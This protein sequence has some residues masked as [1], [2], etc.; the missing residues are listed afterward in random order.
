[1]NASAKR[2]RRRQRRIALLAAAGALILAIVC[3]GLYLGIKTVLQK[4]KPATGTEV[5]ADGS[6]E[7]GSQSGLQNPSGSTVKIT[8]GGDIL[9]EDPILNYFNNGTWGSYMEALWPWL[10][11][12][13]LSVVNMEVPIGGEELGITGIDYSFN[14]PAITASNV[15]EQGIEVVSLAN[16]HAFDRGLQG[17][18]NT[19]QNLTNAGIGFTGTAAAPEE[20][21]SI[22]STEINGMKIG[23]VSYTYNTNQPQEADW[24]VN[25]FESIYSDRSDALIEDIRKAKAENDA[26]LAC[27]H[28][29][30]E[31]TYDLNEDQKVLAQ[32]AADAGADVILGNHPHCIQPAGWIDTADGRKTLCYYSLGNLASSAYQV[33][34]ADEAFQNMYELGALASF[35]LQK[36]GDKIVVNPLEI[37]PYIN[38]FENDYSSFALVPLRDYTEDMAA[39]HD[40]RQFSD[41]FTREWLAAQVDQVYAGSGLNVV[42]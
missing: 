20:G 39:R 21:R 40:Q 36:D 19:H 17:I 37:V 25:T 24:Q 16:N 29:G 31:F 42:K 6:L 22:Y 35:E 2:R 12:D 8:A 4:D 13:D 18:I 38:Q 32:A 26:V 3:G 5:L 27:I 1:M 30:T 9:L 28:W 10:K 15:K 14:S 34:R 11:N 41:L 7:T 23:I 33:D